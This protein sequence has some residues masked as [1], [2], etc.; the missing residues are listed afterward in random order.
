VRAVA[1]TSGIGMTTALGLAPRVLDELF[2]QT[3]TTV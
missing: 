2:D 3:P 1:V